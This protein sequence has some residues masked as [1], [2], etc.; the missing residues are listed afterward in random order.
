MR[1]LTNL[2]ICAGQLIKEE[3]LSGEWCGRSELLT[4]IVF[5][6]NDWIKLFD[7]R[8]GY[9]SVILPTY[10]TVGGIPFQPVV[11]LKIVRIKKKERQRQMKKNVRD[12]GPV[13]AYEASR[14]I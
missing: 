8:A 14:W 1:E 4:N 3:K 13:W 10:Q 6:C 9:G 12:I 7:G 11:G 2:Q 5:V